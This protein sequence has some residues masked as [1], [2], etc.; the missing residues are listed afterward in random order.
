MS[1]S[2]GRRTR[3][4]LRRR[5]TRVRNGQSRT[6]IRAKNLQDI[7]VRAADAHLIIA[8][9][10][11]RRGSPDHRR[12]GFRLAVHATHRAPT[13]GAVGLHARSCRSTRQSRR[14]A[15]R[16]AGRRSSCPAVRRACRKTG[17]PRC[18][19][20]VFEA[21][22]AGARHLL[23]DAADDGRARW[24]S[25]AGAASRV[26]AGDHHDRA[27]RAAVR[28]SPGELR[29]WAS[30]GD[31][32]DVRTGGICRHGDE[33]QRAGRRNG[34]AGSQQ[35]TR[36]CSIRR[37]RIRITA[38][39][40]CAISPSTSA[41]A[42]RLDDGVVREGGGGRIRAQVGDGRVVCGLSGGVDS[43]VAA[44]LIHR[45]IGDRLTCI[46]VDNGVLRQDEA[47]QIRTRFERLEA[48]AR[49]RGCVRALPRPASRASSIRSRSARS[50]ARRSS[51]CS[52]PKPRSSARSIFWPGHA[53]SGRHRERLGHRAV[54]RDQEPSQRGRAARA[55]A[56]QAGRAAADA[57]QGRSPRGRQGA[58]AGRRVRLAAAVPRPGSGGAHS[59][60]GDAHRA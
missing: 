37:L 57:V 27:G 31:F 15:R 51:T 30:H 25:R 18:E 54:A 35:C 34:G 6:T 7:V 58:G 59:R 3:R 19:P 5:A 14:F 10:F 28:T 41:G 52:R 2:P 24:R 49:L 33:R 50:S 12:S 55:D 43:T 29:V 8:R 47:E 39:R 53:L 38:P 42:R 48:A 45:A 16:E 56:V 11:H 9:S 17:A 20:A 23:R 60:R 36:S 22:R 32:V 4:T 44:L 40:S 21:R 46:F 13:A 26:R 1:G